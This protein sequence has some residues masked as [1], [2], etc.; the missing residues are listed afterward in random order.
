MMSDGK[1]SQDSGALVPFGKY[2][3]QPLEVLKHDQGYI[4]W[5]L[6]QGWVQERYPRFHTLIINNFQEP[7]E[8]PEHNA[9][10]VRFLDETFQ[11][12]CLALIMAH[13]PL[14][15]IHSALGSLDQCAF[16]RNAIDVLMQVS[17][18]RWNRLK[19]AWEDGRGDDYFVAIVAIEIKP[20]LGDDFPSVLR[21]ALSMRPP[22]EWDGRCLRVVVIQDFQARAVTFQQVQKMFTASDV[23]LLQTEMIEQ[24]PPA[25]FYPNTPPPRPY[26]Q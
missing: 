1:E 5:M 18:W 4:E 3:G 24:S 10:Q 15:P 2:R 19:R 21:Q 8:T 12:C 22:K 14:L 23:L 16:E 6:E 26:N 25:V 11:N 17:Y 13:H 9:L 7:S 20:S